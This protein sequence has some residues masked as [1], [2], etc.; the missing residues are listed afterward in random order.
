MRKALLLAALASTAI[1]L[2]AAPSA[3]TPR[4]ANPYGADT[5]ITRVADLD[6]PATRSGRHVYHGGGRAYWHHRLGA[7]RW[8]HDQYVNAGYPASRYEGEVYYTTF[9]GDYCCGY[10]RHWPWMGRYHYGPRYWGWM[11]HRHHHHW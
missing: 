2:F 8:L 3:A 10:R 4:L 5:L 6:R 1:A 11:G 7:G 9:P